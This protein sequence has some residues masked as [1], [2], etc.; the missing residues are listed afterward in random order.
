MEPWFP[1]KRMG[2]NAPTLDPVT[3]VVGHTGVSC[4]SLSHQI[5]VVTQLPDDRV[6]MDELELLLRV[7]SRLISSRM[8]FRRYAP[9]VWAISQA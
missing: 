3:I 1:L 4:K 7:P 9:W 6:L 8:I 2:E 5:S